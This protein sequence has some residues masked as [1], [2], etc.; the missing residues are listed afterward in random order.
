MTEIDAMAQ[1]E[2]ALYDLLSTDA[3]LTDSGDPAYCGGGF[4]NRVLPDD[5]DKVYPFLVFSLTTSNEFRTFGKVYR[6][7]YLYYVRVVDEAGSIDRATQVLAR[8]NALL[9]FAHQNPGDVPMTNFDLFYSARQGRITSSP[10]LMG[11][12]YQNAIDSYRVE[13]APK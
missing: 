3:V 1:L 13:V 11:V 12:P 5:G 6:Y 2:A 4:W 7:Q 9:Q 10:V 8:V